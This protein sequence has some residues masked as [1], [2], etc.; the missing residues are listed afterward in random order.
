MSESMEERAS[1]SR[2]NGYGGNNDVAPLTEEDA[3]PEDEE[4]PF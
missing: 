3:P 4:P 1:S 2:P